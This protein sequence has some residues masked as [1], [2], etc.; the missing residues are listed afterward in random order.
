VSSEA[1]DQL[2]LTHQVEH[3]LV[4][5]LFNSRVLERGDCE[6][7]RD[8]WATSAR[9][10]PDLGEPIFR[11]GAESAE[12][13]LVE[14]GEVLLRISL[15]SGMVHLQAS[16]AS[17]APIDALLDRLH[18]ELPAPDPSS[19]HE[20]TVT[21]WTYGPQGPMPSWR[22]IAVPSWG[23][24]RANY[25]QS[26]RAELERLMTA[27]QPAHGGQL[28]LWHGIAGTGKTFGLRA[29]AWEWRDWCDF[30]YIVDPD[31]FFGQHADY[32]MSVLLQPEYMGGYQVPSMHG[33]ITSTRM[34][35][36]EDGDEESGGKAWR[37]LVLEDTG[38]LLTPDAK[39]V[40][41][42]GLSR[43]LNVVDGL[44]GQGLRVLVLVTTN[45]PIKKLHPAVTRPGRCAA[46]VEF[47]AL[48]G[49]EAASWL[50]ARGVA[51][52]RDGSA[53]LAELFATAEGRDPSETHLVGFGDDSV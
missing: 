52:G 6:L 22:S 21:F 29:L 30:H 40:I 42:Q 32:L 7:R 43:F 1:R 48:D 24:I 16:A 34:E 53:T 31:T 47:T 41:G 8:G 15:Y 25:A 11:S 18:Q 39:M 10:L 12:S 20:V 26:T 5:G 44:I 37:V 13:V 33:F 50:A 38:E 9:E 23:E 2:R 46:N 14:A 3:D 51:N 17:R 28:V 45:E 49:D 36:S 4:D 19:A 27:F 35:V